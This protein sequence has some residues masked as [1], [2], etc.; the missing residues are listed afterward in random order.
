MNHQNFH[1]TYF[2]HNVKLVI[3]KILK[4]HHLIKIKIVLISK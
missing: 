3:K 1:H 2:Y 4:N